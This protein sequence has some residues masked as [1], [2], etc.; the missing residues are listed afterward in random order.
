LLYHPGW[1]QDD[2]GGSDGP[3]RRGLYIR[4]LFYGVAV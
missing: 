2:S 3:N 4:G 1:I